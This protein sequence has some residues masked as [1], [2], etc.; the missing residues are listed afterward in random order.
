M[1]N[2]R[3]GAAVNGGGEIV[4]IRN[5]AGAV[6]AFT[7][8]TDQTIWN[9][10]PDPSSDTGYSGVST[11]L[12]GTAVAAGVDAAGHI[13]LLAASTTEPQVSYVI[14]T[15]TPGARW[16][17]VQ[18]LATPKPSGTVRI[19]SIIT[20]QIGGQLYVAILTEIQ[21][22]GT[23]VYD[24]CWSMWNSAKPA[25][26]ST[27]FQTPSTNCVWLGTS[28]ANVAFACV[29]G[30]ISV[31]NVASKKTSPLQ[32]S[33]Q[34]PSLAVTTTLNAAQQNEIFAILNDGNVYQLTGGGKQ[35]YVWNQIST[36]GSF[37]QIA[38]AT[39]GV[40][41]HILALSG[42]KQVYHWQTQ[43]GQ[44]SNGAVISTNAVLIGLA[45]NDLNNVEF[46]TVGAGAG[47][48]RHTFL[49]ATST[50]WVA[51]ALEVP[52]EGAV[53]EFISYS[54]DVT[55]ADTLGAPLPHT[56]VTVAVSEQ[57]E[58]MI[59][60]A[61][62]FIDPTTPAQVSTN[63]AS[64]L[65]LV[66][67]TTTL[68]V[69]MLQ[70]SVPFMTPGTSIAIDQTAGTQQTLATV[71]G[72]DLMNAKTLNGGYL[73]PDTYRTTEA[74]TQLAMAV[75]ACMNFD[76]TP[77][78]ATEFVLRR[79]PQRGAWLCRNTPAASLGRIRP[80]NAQSWRVSFENNT[81]RYETLTA[82][83][84]AALIDEQQKT[85]ASS[86]LLTWLST[87]GDFVVG[88][89]EDIIDITTATFIAI[90]E[91]IQ[92]AFTFVL[93]GVAYVYN[94]V[95]TVIEEAFDAVQSFFARVGVE[96]KD[97]FQW[98]GFVFDWP[99]MLRTQQAIA[100]TVEQFL[101]FLPQAVGGIQSRLDSA[102]QNLT[103]NNIEKLFNW[104]VDTVA[105]N[106]T[107]GGYAAMNEEALPAAATALTNASLANNIIY[108][109]LVDNG[110]SSAAPPV[111]LPPSI[112]Q[113]F[114]S[115]LSEVSSFVT[116]AGATQAF[117][118]ALAYFKN[119][120]GS[121]DNLFSQLLAGLLKIAQGVALVVISGV[122]AL[123]DALLQLVQSILQAMQQL[124]TTQW[125]IPFL[126]A[127]YSKIT[128][129]QP[130][131]MINLIA[132]M[133]AVPATIL[134]NVATKSAPFPDAESLTAF[135]TSFDAQ[136]ILAASGLGGTTNE[137]GAAGVALLE[138]TGLPLS[139]R[140]AY[141]L[142]LFSSV[143]TII[144]GWVSAVLDIIPTESKPPVGVRSPTEE[145]QVV[146]SIAAFV[147]ELVSQ[148]CSIPWL[149]SSGSLQC[150][151][152]VERARWLWIVQAL[153]VLL[154]AIFLATA[155]II[156][157]NYGDG[158]VL[159]AFFY[160]ICESLAALMAC[161]SAQNL[162]I[163][164]NVTYAV[165][166]LF[167]LGRLSAIVDESG[168][169]SLAVVGATDALGYTVSGL[170]SLVA[171]SKSGF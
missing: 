10:Y 99:N 103:Q 118:E 147:F 33:E 105:G 43:Q 91:G 140:S 89:A 133:G 135:V 59:N 44:F 67:Q 137:D 136:A 132:L 108:N 22:G 157:E 49:D 79:S 26:S 6:E 155:N 7:T 131:T 74:T 58:V 4:A 107:I 17:S 20:A 141:L 106:A 162:V 3:I 110:P 148:A 92:V 125:N 57:A 124:L 95:I 128:N 139:A 63:G 93:D 56:P 64:M 77:D 35:I 94:A 171:T 113:Q 32:V 1:Q 146:L 82:E 50:N 45:T 71:T 123:I 76:G 169:L 127:L 121:V 75:N 112:M 16:G 68:G 84:A 97:L 150:S 52:T 114:E 5:G 142:S 65:S 104:A 166:G 96:Y 98:L 42:S 11:G 145:L 158:G 119:I 18:K 15:G 85:L 100:Y 39:S 48:L 31:Y 37:V 12:Q 156:P 129:G 154:D 122:Q 81:V 73:L 27:L 170:C 47:A 120:S 86:S 2:Y 168:G 115:F 53:Q 102:F 69:P 24:L 40:D 21:N 30:Q 36:G 25:V 83:A 143:F 138:S 130:L 8:A 55:F 28:G 46:F 160:A 134:C 38:A 29:D 62:Y 51:A 19:A 167:K 159:V 153:G 144:Y 13:V 61:V 152:P 9:F 41:T 117:Q 66:Q 109:G 163:A 54:T 70:I 80:R 90:A 161:L 88:V 87:I 78:G 116:D 111:M 126:T 23:T 14:E 151:T 72:A 60:G 101:L 164:A 34:I 165:P 149:S